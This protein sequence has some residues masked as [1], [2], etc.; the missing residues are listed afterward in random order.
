MESIIKAWEEEH[1]SSRLTSLPAD[2]DQLYQS[3]R[4]KLKDQVTAAS[5]SIERRMAEIAFQR[6]DFCLQDL[7]QLRKE[8]LLIATSRNDELDTDFL[9]PWEQQYFAEIKRIEFFYKQNVTTPVS[10]IPSQPVPM[11]A[12]VK[13][14]VSLPRSAPDPVLPTESSAADQGIE[15]ASPPATDGHDAGSYVTIRFL[16]TEGA[17]IGVDMREYGPFEAGEIAFLPEVHA[18][19]FITNG[20]ARQVFPST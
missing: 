3:E 6:L 12:E 4:N 15:N 20:V 2:I 8:K 9:L 16:K 19:I 1:K 10:I 5:G 11:Q 18:R 14:S 17:I 7:F 13:P